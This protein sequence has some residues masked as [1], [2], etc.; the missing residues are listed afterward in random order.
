MQYVAL[1][2]P[3]EDRGQPQGIVDALGDGF[4]P[5]GQRSVGQ[6]DLSGLADGGEQARTTAEHFGGLALFLK[7]LGVAHG[8]RDL[9]SVSLDDLER[10]AVEPARP[11]GMQVD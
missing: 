9:Y 10:F 7:T 1:K 5:F 11:A 2:Q 6:R 8:D 3:D 4:Q